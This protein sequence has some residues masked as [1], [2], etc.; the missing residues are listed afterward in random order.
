M[1]HRVDP[2]IARCR[3]PARLGLVV[4]TIIG[5]IVGFYLQEEALN[6][7]SANERA[8]SRLATGLQTEVHDLVCA[9]TSGAW[10]ERGEII[11]GLVVAAI[12][13]VK[14]TRSHEQAGRDF[15]ATFGYYHYRLRRELDRAVAEC[16]N[17]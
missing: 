13:E 5:T 2:V 16:P 9:L 17:G 10:K 7:V 4:G 15:L 8:T 11:D 14:A 12:R 1:R 6:R 3:R